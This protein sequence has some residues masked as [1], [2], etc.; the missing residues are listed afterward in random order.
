MSEIKFGLLDLSDQP[1]DNEVV[2]L[3]DRLATFSAQRERRVLD[4]IASDAA[5]AQ[6]GF[7]SR[8]SSNPIASADA[9]RGRRRRATPAEPTRHLAIRLGSS[10]Y[11]RFVAYADRYQLT[12]QDALAKLLDNV[13]E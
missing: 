10:E 8:E 9:V 6:H 2:P 5:A 13:A 3:S 12:Y 7:T 11:N 1:K 4:V